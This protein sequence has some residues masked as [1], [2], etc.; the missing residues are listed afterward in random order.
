MN[1]NIVAV[2]NI[3]MILQQYTENTAML[4]VIIVENVLPKV[5]D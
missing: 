2:Q 4:K 3:C 1:A 5:I